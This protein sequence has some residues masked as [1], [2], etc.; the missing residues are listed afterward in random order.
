MLFLKN[1]LLRNILP[2]L[3]IKPWWC[4]ILLLPRLVRLQNTEVGRQSGVHNGY[5]NSQGCRPRPC[6]KK[7]QTLSVRVLLLWTDTMTK[8]TIIKN[9]M[10][11]ELP[12]RFRGS[13]QYHQG[14]SREAS[15]QAWCRR[16]CE[17]Y[18]FI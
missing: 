15:R 6:L 16:S 1:V 18:T 10:S 2:F 17:F 9:N 4:S 7:T 3:D 5:Q 11:L 13:V 8:A 12:Y 14:R